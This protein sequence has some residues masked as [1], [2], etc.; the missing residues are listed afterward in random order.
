M[1]HAS[2]RLVTNV[3]RLPS[4]STSHLPKFPPKEALFLRD[5]E[6]PQ[7]EFEPEVWASLQPPPPSALSAFASR[8]GLSS[9]LS[10]TELIQQACTHSSFVAFH[11]HHYPSEPAPISNAQLA[12]IGNSLMGLFAT[13]HL[14]ATYPY[15]PTRVLK[16]AITAHVGSMTCASVA[17]EMGAAPLL[18]WRRTPNTP[19]RP[20][21]LHPDALS[22]IPKAITALIYQKRSLLSARKFVQSYFL[23]REIDLRGM[24]KFRDPKAALLEMVAKFGAERPKSRLLRETGRFSRAPVFV[25]GVFS[26]EDQL[27]EGFGSSLKMAEYRAAE[28]ALLRVYLTR[29]PSHLVQLPTSTFSQSLGDV[30]KTVPEGEYIPPDLVESEIMYASSGKSGAAPGITSQS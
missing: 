20:G 26:G 12:T 15:L 25:V 30:F 14:N 17:N 11:Q 9:V 27:G 2:K 29:T 22:S 4:V 8:I 21:V 19:N 23:T 16:A 10:T 3:A 28:D 5:Q 24:I 6:I 13:E 7:P 18:R 1:G